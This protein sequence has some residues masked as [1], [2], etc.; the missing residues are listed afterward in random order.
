MKRELDLCR[1]I[2]TEVEKWPTTVTPTKAEIEGYSDDEVNYNV[3][4]LASPAAVS[5]SLTALPTYMQALA[6]SLAVWCPAKPRHM[7]H[8]DGHHQLLTPQD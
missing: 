1:Q 5:S 8:R 6:S 3:W 4:L 2:L 7:H